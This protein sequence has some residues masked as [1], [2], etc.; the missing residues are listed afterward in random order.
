MRPFLV[1]AGLI[2][3]AG[4]V[5]CLV[6]IWREFRPLWAP[7]W[8]Q[9]YT[10]RFALP[11]YVARHRAAGRV[12]WL[13]EVQLH[14]RRLHDRAKRAAYLRLM[15]IPEPEPEYLE[16]AEWLPAIAPAP[17]HHVD[18]LDFRPAPD[19]RFHVLAPRALDARAHLERKGLRLRQASPWGTPEYVDVWDPDLVG[20]A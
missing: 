14:G 5:V 2:A 17:E 7:L 1:A 18:E 13:A 11:R 6:L 8:S 4:I 16:P 12:S 3:V 20:A 9:Q 19:A 15:V 10:D